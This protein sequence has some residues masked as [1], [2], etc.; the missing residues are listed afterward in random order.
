M[1]QKA[2]CEAPAQL[3]LSREDKGKMPIQFGSIAKT[4]S[5]EAEL[6]SLPSHNLGAVTPTVNLALASEVTN[7][8]ANAAPVPKGTSKVL[9]R[10]AGTEALSSA[11]HLRYKVKNKAPQRAKS[12]VTMTS[13]PK[14]PSAKFTP[15]DELH[16]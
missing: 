3:R 4:T 11:S 5:R 8:I 2:P 7:G 12:E 13:L 16:V 9:S 15:R 10:K 1:K 6:V 14:S